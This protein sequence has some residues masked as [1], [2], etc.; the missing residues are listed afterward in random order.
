MLQEANVISKNLAKLFVSMDIFITG[1]YFTILLQN[2]S[3]E[4]TLENNEVK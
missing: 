4:D 3:R 2:F 1:L